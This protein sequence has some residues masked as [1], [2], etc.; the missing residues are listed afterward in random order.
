MLFRCRLINKK[1]HVLKSFYIEGRSATEVEEGLK[2]FIWPQGEW[3]IIEAE[4]EESKCDCDNGSCY[5][6]T[7][8]FYHGE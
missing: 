8:E 2:M 1:D 5:D 7:Y 4:A 3:E 6:C